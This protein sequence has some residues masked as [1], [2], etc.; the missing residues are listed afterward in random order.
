MARAGVGFDVDTD[1]VCVASEPREAWG[2]GGIL[3]DICLKDK[4]SEIPPSHV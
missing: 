2:A 1:S 3:K 4:L